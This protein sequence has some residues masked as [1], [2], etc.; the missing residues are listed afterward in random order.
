VAKDKN[1]IGIVFEV[2]F[3]ILVVIFIYQ[4]I[5][6]ITGNSPTDF[7]IL[8]TGF[9]IISSYILVATYNFARFIG[10]VDEF[11]GNAKI[12]MKDTKEFMINTKDSFQKIKED[13]NEIKS[14][15]K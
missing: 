9:G 13:I 5:A 2:I 8:Y 15:K 10:R 12:F 7:T 4:L 6:K 11:M 1:I 14:S 3:W